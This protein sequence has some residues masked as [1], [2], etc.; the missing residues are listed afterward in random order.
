MSS[1]S[2]TE[3]KINKTKVNLSIKLLCVELGSTVVMCIVL[4]LMIINALWDDV[5]IDTIKNDWDTSPLISARLI[6][7]DE[8]C[9]SDE[10]PI[11]QAWWWG[12]K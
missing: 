7:K 2:D 6:G 9:K 12:L 8:D 3:Q 10:E 1:D 4:W 11:S 5:Y